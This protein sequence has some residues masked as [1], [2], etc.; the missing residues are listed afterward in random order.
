M[1]SF[2]ILKYDLIS[3]I[4]YCLLVTFG[5]VNIYSSTFNESFISI[6]DSSTVVG[7]QIIFLILS[8]VTFIL[9]IFTKPNFTLKKLFQ[10]NS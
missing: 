5:I 2:K 10:I 4:S 7:K 1:N 6:F 9:I 3:I 8:S